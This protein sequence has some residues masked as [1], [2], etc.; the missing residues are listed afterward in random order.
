MV[1]EKRSYPRYSQKGP[2]HVDIIH[3][4]NEQLDSN[5]RFEGA[6]RDISQSGIRLHGKHPLS[7]GAHLE[8]LVE[9]ESNQTKYKLQGSVKWVSETTE[10]EYVAGLK[11]DASSSDFSAWQNSFS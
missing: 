2:I 3:I 10:R 6:M 8:L 4:S 11:I 7:Q 5:I 9:V 1:E